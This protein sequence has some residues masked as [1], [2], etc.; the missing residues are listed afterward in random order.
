MELT[1]N[2][3]SIAE[4]MVDMFNN[5][6]EKYNAT[7]EGCTTIVETWKRNK[8]DRFDELF[9]NIPGY[10]A[11]Q[12]CIVL[13]KDIYRAFDGET[14]V[15]FF[16]YLYPLIDCRKKPE[17]NGR[18]IDEWLKLYQKNNRILNAISEV[19]ATVINVH[20]LE[21]IKAERITAKLAYD[22]LYWAP[23]YISETLDEY[24]RRSSL[25]DILKEY[26]DQY[27][28]AEVCEKINEVYPEMKAHAGKKTSKITRKFCEIAGVKDKSADF[29]RRYAAYAD[30]INPIVL[31]ET[32][33]ISWHPLDYLTQSNGNSWLSCH[34]IG[35]EDG[36]Y[37]CYSS[38]TLSYMLD[39]TSL[40]IYV[41]DKN[42]VNDSA[43]YWTHSKIHRQ[44]FHINDDGTTILQ[45]RLYPDDQS[46]WGRN[47]DYVSYRQ[48]REIVEDVV[49]TAFG[50]VN[51]W[52]NKKG[53]DACRAAIM[54]S[55]GTH[56]PDYHH[57]DNV[58]VSY[59]SETEKKFN[60]CIGHRPICP[61]C[62]CEHSDDCC[63][64]GS[65]WDSYSRYECYECGDRYNE[66]NMHYID[67]HW[68]CENCCTYCEYHNQWEIGSR[69]EFTYVGDYGCVCDEG[70][71]E[72][73]DS[74][75]IVKCE[76]CGDWEVTDYAFI[77]KEAGTDNEHYFCTDHCRRYW[78]SSR[79]ND[80]IEY[81]MA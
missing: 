60:L 70:L 59:N 66:E 17:Y 51:R 25:F 12:H 5:A 75:D 52:S 26:H 28:D 39:E 54:R 63:T 80:G 69:D 46:D 73:R 47:T 55:C 62:G 74:G 41:I 8:G 44:M 27:I 61:S 18:N 34:N 15:D 57:Y 49:A 33:I 36:D 20:G 13:D 43:P 9:K 23:E 53:T 77:V 32:M 64:D 81:E 11:E 3:G 19:P 22:T 37:G 24:R 42:L 7:L 16:R 68:Y 56:Y 45:S 29:E 35:F 2:G 72:L 79:T 6:N 40:V 65:C 71:D 58:N 21:Q 31:N 67:G 10:N 1:Y 50:L 78:V 30:A 14:I 38:G 4:E 76:Y 48:Y